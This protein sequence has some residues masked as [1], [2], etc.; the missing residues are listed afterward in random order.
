MIG[1][2]AARSDAVPSV[3]ELAEGLADRG[4]QILPARE[5]ARRAQHRLD[6]GRDVASLTRLRA[7]APG[8]T[9]RAHMHVESVLD[10]Q[11]FP[12]AQQ[13]TVRNSS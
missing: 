8:Q 9:V 3:G 5:R 6:A 7:R 10:E 1:A 12:S 4:R 2:R 11:S 13:M